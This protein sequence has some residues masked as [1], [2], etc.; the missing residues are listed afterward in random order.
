MDGIYFYFV[1]KHFL[2]CRYWD[3]NS[4]T[5]CKQKTESLT[6]SQTKPW[7]SCVCRTGLLKTLWEMEKLFVTSNFSFSYMFSTRLE[8]FLPFS[9]NSKCRLLTLSFWK[10]LKF[11]VWERVNLVLKII[12]LK[13][14]HT[15]NNET[16]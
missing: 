8:N 12:S 3:F 7:F 13:V 10:R 14:T 16:K 5:K 4:H 15:W 9:S 1:N 11:V 2:V 6:F